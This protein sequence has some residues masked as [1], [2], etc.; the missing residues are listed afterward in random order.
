[1]TS[2]RKC[3][4][5]PWGSRLDHGWKYCKHCLGPADF[6][7]YTRDLWF[8]CPGQE[9]GAKLLTS[10][11]ANSCCSRGIQMMGSAFETMDVL[12]RT[13][14]RN[15]TLWGKISQRMA[16]TY[17]LV[18]VW[19][20]FGFIGFFKACHALKLHS[21]QAAV[22][23]FLCF[24]TDLAASKNLAGFCASLRSYVVRMAC[25]CEIHWWSS[26]KVWLPMFL[27]RSLPRCWQSLLV[28]SSMRFKRA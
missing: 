28:P 3:V 14:W 24:G 5:R 20:R 11:L 10:C 18:G 19:G 27:V 17:G 21:C 8:A 23:T 4:R 15:N 7:H 26:W 13:S 25:F 6:G 12:G 22:G 1:M 9:T 2:R 16:I